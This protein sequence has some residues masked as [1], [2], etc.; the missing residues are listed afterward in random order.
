MSQCAC[1]ADCCSHVSPDTTGLLSARYLTVD[2]EWQKRYEAQAVI[3]LAK[4]DAW[5]RDIREVAKRWL[6]LENREYWTSHWKTPALCFG[7]FR[8]QTRKNRRHIWYLDSY[9]H[10][11]IFGG[12]H[13]DAVFAWINA[14]CE[15]FLRDGIDA[16]LPP[17]LTQRRAFG[18]DEIDEDEE[19]DIEESYFDDFKNE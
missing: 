19:T 12:P 17:I 6:R 13:S 2:D 7:D 9:A 14:C 16:D 8:N 3:E 5:M 1:P 10:S 11:V 4:G 18:C 15:C